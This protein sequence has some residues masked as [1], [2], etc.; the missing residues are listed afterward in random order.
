M[1]KEKITTLVNRIL[2]PAYETLEF[3]SL[4]S[5]DENQLT[6]DD[7]GGENIAKKNPR[8]SESLTG[9]IIK[10]RRRNT[11]RRMM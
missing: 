10:G 1:Y 7:E 5:L 11:H 3:Q 9:C 8:I 6:L 4:R 2:R